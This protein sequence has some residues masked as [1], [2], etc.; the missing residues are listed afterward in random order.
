MSKRRCVYVRVTLSGRS[1]FGRI[2]ERPSRCKHRATAKYDEHAL[3]T[4]HYNLAVKMFGGKPKC[5]RP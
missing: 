2:K 5:A 3:C 4:L 1:G